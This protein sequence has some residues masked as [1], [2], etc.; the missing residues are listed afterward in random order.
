MNHKTILSLLV[1]AAL[2]GNLAACSPGSDSPA[3]PS[4]AGADPIT[5]LPMSDPSMPAADG[6]VEPGTASPV[7]PDAMPQ[8]GASQLSASTYET[9]VDDVFAVF[10]GAAY[11]SDVLALPPYSGL[12]ELSIERSSYEG[13]TTRSDVCDNGGTAELALDASGARVVVTDR[14]GVFDNC[15][16]GSLLIDGEIELLNTDNVNVTSSGLSIEGDSMTR[17]FSGGVAYGD[18]NNYGGGSARWWTASELNWSVDSGERIDFA[19]TNA[20]TAYQIDGGFGQ[21]MSGSFTLTSDDRSIAVTTT[22]AFASNRPDFNDPNYSPNA[23]H[24]TSGTLRIVAGDGSSILIEADNG[25]DAS[26]RVTLAHDGQRESFEKPW[27]DWDSV[28]RAGPSP[29]R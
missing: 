9:V 21:T 12:R 18:G 13:S 28:L 14:R 26:A 16:S 10:T 24:Y 22:K 19:V 15:Q 23:W 27:S 20:N 25:D 8:P 6:A 29:T 7:T 2:G 11:G 4:A 17:S 5:G 3:D 1:T